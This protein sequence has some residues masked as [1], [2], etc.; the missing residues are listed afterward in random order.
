MFT[1]NLKGLLEFMF[2]AFIF[3]G[4]SEN[5]APNH[6]IICVFG[7]FLDTFSDF[8]DSFHNIALFKLSKCPMH[9]GVVTV[10]IEFFGLA[11]DIKCFFVYHVHV[12]E[13]GK[14]IICVR[15]CVIK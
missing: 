3:T 10:P 11:A 6:P 1:F 2:G 14:I 12:E 15:V 7:L 4:R 8:L 13:E 9:V 5:E